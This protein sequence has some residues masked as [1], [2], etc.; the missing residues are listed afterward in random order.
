[1]P[2][3][4]ETQLRRLHSQRM[5]DTLATG[6]KCLYHDHASGTDLVA[7]VVKVHFDDIPPYY[8][9]TIEGREGERETVRTRLTPFGDDATP[10]ASEATHAA[11][12]AT[13]VEAVPADSLSSTPPA[14]LHVMVDKFKRELS[15]S[16]GTV[17]AV[18]EQACEL[19][20][21]DVR[22]KTLIE[23]AIAAW[24]ALYTPSSG[25]AATTA[26]SSSNAAVTSGA[27]AAPSGDVSHMLELM[28]ISGAA[29]SASRLFKDI[30]ADADGAVTRRE[31][32]EYFAA[33][34]R[35]PK[36]AAALFA[37]LDADGDGLIDYAEFKQLY[38]ACRRDADAEAK[39]WWRA[40]FVSGGGADKLFDAIDADKYGCLT[41]RELAA[42]LASCGD[43]AQM[44]ARL[45]AAIDGDKDGLIDRSEM[46]DAMAW[47]NTADADAFALPQHGSSEGTADANSA[48]GGAFS[49]GGRS[50]AGR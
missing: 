23:Q 13:N 9:I 29:T 33:H 15:L 2:G 41:R 35:E 17:K 19:L 16:D 44:A 28:S 6:A 43:D 12:E 25:A 36:L 11:V 49:T 3:N 46:R 24:H 20:N 27:T 50:N 30:D 45:L 18:V 34:G 21:V 8:T 26:S 32:S 39:R 10:R 38:Q 47:A 1:M 42:Y 40:L 5:A 4:A 7:R 14:P 31:L 22:D 48:L 37:T